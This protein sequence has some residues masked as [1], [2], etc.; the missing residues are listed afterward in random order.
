MIEICNFSLYHFMKLRLTG[1]LFVLIF[2]MSACGIQ[3]HNPT[4]G[5]YAG[6]TQAYVYPP[7]KKKKPVRKHFIISHANTTYLGQ[8][9]QTIK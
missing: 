7:E 8:T 3:K 1:F 2:L 9:G 4:L 5:P 6:K